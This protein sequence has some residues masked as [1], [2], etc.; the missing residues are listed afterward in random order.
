MV[1]VR[2]A[3]EGRKQLVLADIPLDAGHYLVRDENQTIQ[4]VSFNYP[5]KESVQEFYSAD[6]LQSLI[7]T[8][9]FKQIQLI[10]SPDVNFTETLQ[11]LNNGKQLWKHFVMLAIFFLLC[12]MAIIRFWK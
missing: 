4:S 12:E 10:E 6:E 1:T 8:S 11:N 2:N 5:R 3:G 7:K 9:G